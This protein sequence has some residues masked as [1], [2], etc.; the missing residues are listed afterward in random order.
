MTYDHSKADNFSKQIV[1]MNDPQHY[2]NQTDWSMASPMVRYKQ[3]LVI[4]QKEQHQLF[5]LKRNSLFLLIT[6]HVSPIDFSSF[7]V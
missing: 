5:T 2:I 1:F 7:C 6:L 4:S 3:M